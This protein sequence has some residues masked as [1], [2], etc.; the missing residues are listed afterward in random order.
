VS[1]EA[2]DGRNPLRESAAFEA[3]TAHVGD[4]C[5]EPSVAVEL[6]EVGSY[7]FFGG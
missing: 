3:F 7:R 5:E 2:A 1:L 4:R 6:N